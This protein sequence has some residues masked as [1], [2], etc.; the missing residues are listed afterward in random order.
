MNLLQASITSS[1]LILVIAA[2]RAMTKYRLPKTTFLILWAVAMARLILPYSVSTV[3][4]VYNIVIFRGMNSVFNL[5]S[6]TS[7]T[8]GDII[9]LL[10]I[11]LLGT[12]VTP[13][14]G[15]I[16]VVWISGAVLSGLFYL[17]ALIRCQKINSEALP[18][19]GN[20]KLDQWRKDQGLRRN[21]RILVSDKLTT[22]IA[23]GIFRPK[24]ILPKFMDLTDD[25]QRTYV[26]THELVHIKR[27]HAVWKFLLIVILCVHWFN[28]VV[29]LMYRL[30]NR[31]LEHSCDELVVSSLPYD[32]R[33]GYAM[34]L[35]SMARLQKGPRPIASGFVKNS[36][37]QRILS[38]LKYKKT[39][40]SAA[41]AAAVI[42]VC[43]TLSFATTSNSKFERSL[44]IGE[45]HES[46]RIFSGAVYLGTP[47]HPYYY[48]DA[49]P[50]LYGAVR[51][52]GAS[53]PISVP[54]I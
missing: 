53:A 37:E 54:G 16:S 38:V 40:F 45:T 12:S 20:E 3:F 6:F 4:S 18:V 50:T 28:P 27:F 7:T 11:L 32:A 33:A 34:S 14:S 43:I 5:V 26:L 36:V 19:A 47:H 41:L 52:P 48:T 23:T 24:I 29:W 17:G 30:A 2:V 9:T 15:P 49:L 31:D 44:T 1:V 46:V 8:A 22:P 35:L 25:A 10:S 21:I 51:F 39:S 42:T 13:G